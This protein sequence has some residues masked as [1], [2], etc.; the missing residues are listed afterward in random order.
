MIYIKKGPPHRDVALKVA[1][2]KRDPKWKAIPL[3]RPTDPQE[4]RGYG[5]TLRTNYF[6]QLPKKEIR[7]TLLREQHYLC[8][9]C[10]RKLPNEDSVIIEHWFPL[11]EARDTAIDPQ[12]FLGSC[13]GVYSEGQERRSC[14][15]D[16]KRGSCITIDPRKEWM[17]D[18]VQ[19]EHD[20][21]IYFDAPVGLSEQQKLDIDNDINK[22]LCLNGKESELTI[23]RER[24]YRSAKNMLEK[25]RLKNRCSVS[26]V[27]RLI[28]NIEDQEQYPE[29]A[30]V[31][32][33][34]YKRWLKNH[35]Q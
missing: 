34:Y 14:C 33:F 19:Y 7:A 30:G 13:D 18:C 17:M 6:D 16:N 26:T 22:V 29:Y 9:Y 21:T 20:G 31:M 28:Q 35:M 8:A 32:L 11:S 23:G 15:D 12:N 25:L 27:Q 10:M 3:T 5:S 1:E 4:Q 2:I 24:V